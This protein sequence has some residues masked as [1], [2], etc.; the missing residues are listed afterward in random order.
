[1]VFAILFPPA[2]IRGQRPFSTKVY[3]SKEPFKLST[4]SDSKNRFCAPKDFSLQSG[5]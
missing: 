2:I 3:Y 4:D 5:T 1:M